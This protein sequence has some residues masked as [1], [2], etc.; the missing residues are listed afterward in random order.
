MNCNFFADAV[1]QI[2]NQA[3]QVAVIFN[4]NSGG[5]AADNALQLQQLLGL[6]FPDLAPKAPEQIDLF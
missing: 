4:N 3:E 2:K 6:E 5:D 1:R